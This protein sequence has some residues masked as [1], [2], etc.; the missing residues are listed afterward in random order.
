MTATVGV[1]AGR[2]ADEQALLLERAGLRVVIGPAMGTALATEEGPLREVTAG[3]IAR[4]P[5]FLIADT[6]IGIRSWVSAADG[7][8]ERDALLGALGLARIACRGPK[9]QGA[10]RSAGLPIWWQAPGEQLAE[11][12]ER[13]LREPLAGRRVAVQL[14]GEDEPALVGA[15][16]RAGAEVIEVPVYRW[17]VPQ[18]RRPALDLITRTCEGGIDALTFTAAPAVHGLFDLAR[19]AGSADALLDAC[20][21]RVLVA[22][23][24]PVCGAAA[25]AEG[26]AQPRW[27]EHWRLGAL[28]KMVAEALSYT[29]ST[30]PRP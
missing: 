24:G 1:T 10:L 5:D 2:R 15:L 13:V 18:D 26:V 23:V 3:L 19:A 16:E 30:G 4:P 8:G 17:T 11:V 27:P 7:W 9:A 28:V 25:T 20:N 6:G 12:R 22:C 21:T 14:H 29:G